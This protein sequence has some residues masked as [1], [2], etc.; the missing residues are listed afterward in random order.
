[1]AAKVITG[2]ALENMETRCGVVKGVKRFILHDIA[3]S[4]FAASDSERSCLGRRCL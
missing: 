3:G 2:V 1:M 4:D